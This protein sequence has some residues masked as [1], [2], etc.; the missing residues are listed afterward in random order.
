MGSYFSTPKPKFQLTPRR[1]Q[2][3]QELF[4]RNVITSDDI[5]EDWNPHGVLLHFDYGFYIYLNNNNESIFAAANPESG[6][7][8]Q[9][10]GSKPEESY[11]DMISKIEDHILSPDRQALRRTKR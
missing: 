4:D 1:R 2:E 8:R 9:F 3:W 10:W 7:Y 11:Y 5:H 6:G